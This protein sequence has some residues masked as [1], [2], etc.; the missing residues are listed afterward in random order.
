MD[1]NGSRGTMLGPASVDAIGEDFIDAWGRRW[2]AVGE[3]VPQ[4]IDV[5]AMDERRTVDH[6][7]PPEP[8][9]LTL[10]I[11]ELAEKLRPRRLVGGYEYR[12]EQPDYEVAARI[13]AMDEAPRT[14]GFR[15]PESDARF[16]VPGGTARIQLTTPREWPG[17]GNA[18]LAPQNCTATMIGPST[19]L[20]AA[21]C[22]YNGG[23]ITSRD[24]TFGA[25]NV[26]PTAPFGSFLA[27]SL[28]M[29]GAWDRAPTSPGSGWDWDFA[30]LE[31]SPSR[32]NLGR[33]TGWFGAE[34]KM[35]GAQ[36]IVGYPIDKPVPTSWSKGGTYTASP[37]SRYEHNI[38]A[39][40]GDSGAGAYNSEERCTGIQSTEWRIGGRT[41][42]EVRKWDLVT[43]NFF[44][45]YGN[46]PRA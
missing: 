32:P 38:D 19:A 15:P 17:S 18:Y 35:S 9:P 40:P 44:D 7:S 13:L 28:T 23:W 10:S 46:W 31:F 24:I 43:Y 1:D 29:P 3:V 11:E 41:W 12:L 33:T 27:D 21:H 42:N 25:N 30:V 37:G 34:E 2:L 45:A 5:A 6:V 39:V 20:C 26:A 16:I 8:D 4:E 14:K 36:T 22:F